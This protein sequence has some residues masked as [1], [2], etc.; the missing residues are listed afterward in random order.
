MTGKIIGQ[1]GCGLNRFSLSCS[2]RCHSHFARHLSISTLSFQYCRLKLH[3]P[4]KGCRGKSP[5]SRGVFK[6]SLA[7]R[8]LAVEPRSPDS[9]RI[10]R[11]QHR[12]VPRSASQVESC[13]GASITNTPNSHL[14]AGTRCQGHPDGAPTV[15]ITPFFRHRRP[16]HLRQAH[17][18]VDRRS[19]LARA[20]A[21]AAEKK[22]D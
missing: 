2:H 16:F 15:R 21:D 19:Q 3:G 18:M 8:V 14:S 7:L 11:Q 9:T 12:Q 6:M 5:S 22:Q 20:V 13:N 1:E 17:R 10:G 4:S